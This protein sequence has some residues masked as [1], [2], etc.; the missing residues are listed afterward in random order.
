LLD[1][2]HDKSNHYGVHPGRPFFLLLYSTHWAFPPSDTALMCARYWLMRDRPLFDAVFTY[3]PLDQTEGVPSWLFPYPSELLGDFEP[4][5]HK[6]DRCLHLDPR[7]W[8]VGSSR[9]GP[10]QTSAKE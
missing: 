3:Q 9:S 8:E 6:G 2:V 5:A 4:E 1:A 7:N 10:D